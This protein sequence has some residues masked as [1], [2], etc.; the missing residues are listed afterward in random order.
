[1]GKKLE[2]SNKCSD[3]DNF[4]KYNPNLKMVLR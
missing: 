1:M 3:Q 2:R 4:Y